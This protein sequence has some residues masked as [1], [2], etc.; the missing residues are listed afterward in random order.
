MGA[1]W[2][3]LPGMVRHAR[4]VLVSA[5][6]VAGVMSGTLASAAGDERVTGASA[7]RLSFT[8]EGIPFVR[9][10]PECRAGPGGGKAHD[11]APDASQY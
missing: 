4:I 5:A 8:D 9:S 3:K 1:G 7:E 6:A 2:G 11:R 10:G